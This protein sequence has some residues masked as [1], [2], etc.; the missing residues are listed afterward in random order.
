MPPWMNA[1]SLQLG[2]PFMS[3]SPAYRKEVLQLLVQEANR[4]ARELNL[5]EQLPITETNLISTSIYPPRIAKNLRAIGKIATSNYTYYVSVGN[6]FSF[7][8][9]THLQQEDNQLKAKYIL[10]INQMDTNAA[11]QLAT[12]FLTAASMDVAALNRD[13]DVRMN[14]ATTSGQDDQHFVPLYSISWVNRGKQEMPGN[15]AS[16]ELFLP[17]KSLRQL[18]VNKSEYILRTPLQITNLDYV[19][20]QTNIPASVFPF[21]RGPQRSSITNGEYR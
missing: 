2:K 20:S 14:T 12:Q 13:C 18:H 21:R 17:T 3:G 4:V 8:V 9:R 7:L 10:P 11:Y 1:S 19:L 6:K 5:P 15:A 16:V